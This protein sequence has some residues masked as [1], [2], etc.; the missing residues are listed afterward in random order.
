MERLNLSARA[1]NRILKVAL[2]IADLEVAENINGSRI[3]ETIQ[4]HSPDRDA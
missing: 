3:S 2:T 1:Y 4:Y